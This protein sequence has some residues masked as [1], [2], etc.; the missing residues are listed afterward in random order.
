MQYSNMSNNNSK[1][2][3]RE[4]ESINNNNNLPINIEGWAV[5][6]SDLDMKSIIGKGEFGGIARS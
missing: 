5:P 1:E 2:R 3:E 4:R 6:R